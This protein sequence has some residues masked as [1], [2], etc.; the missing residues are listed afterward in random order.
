MIGC[1]AYARSAASSWPVLIGRPLPRPLPPLSRH[2]VELVRLAWDTSI[3]AA[4]VG[5]DVVEQGGVVAVATRAPC[6][7]RP[8]P[9]HPHHTLVRGHRPAQSSAPYRVLPDR[10]VHGDDG[11]NVDIDDSVVAVV[12]VVVAVV[13]VVGVV[14]VALAVV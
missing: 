6:R 5:V 8:H 3:A 14:V 7:R 12:V 10:A 13:V 9:H 1:D 11:C 4:A 2:D